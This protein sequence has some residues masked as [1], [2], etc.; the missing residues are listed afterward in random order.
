MGAD[1]GVAKSKRV[2]IEGNS[3]IIVPRMTVRGERL[4]LKM[5]DQRWLVIC[6]PRWTLLE[7]ESGR[8]NLGQA[9]YSQTET[10]DFVFCYVEDK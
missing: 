3:G 7:G 10:R 9:G 5:D 8:L 1:G 2:Q 6:K 4:P